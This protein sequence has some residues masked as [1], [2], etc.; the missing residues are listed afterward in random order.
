[1]RTSGGISSVSSRGTGGSANAA[2]ICGGKNEEVT[3]PGK[4]ANNGCPGLDQRSSIV[5]E[6]MRRA[7][8]PQV[9]RRSLHH[10]ARTRRHEGNLGELMAVGSSR[11]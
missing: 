4:T 5:E 11:T 7:V 8:D 9:A 10:S 2:D 6:P 3:G 1:M